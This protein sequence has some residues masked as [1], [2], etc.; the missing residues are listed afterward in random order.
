MDRFR[1]T[2]AGGFRLASGSLTSIAQV[3]TSMDP[4][5]RFW[6]RNV[7]QP[8]VAAEFDAT[9]GE[10]SVSS[11]GPRHTPDAWPDW[12]VQL[13]RLLSIT[14]PKFSEEART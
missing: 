9:T 12:V 7:D 10:I 11:W 3:L 5:G 13:R 2:A 14:H 4:L 1:A 6:V 8:L